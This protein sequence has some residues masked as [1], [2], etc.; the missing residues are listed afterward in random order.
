MI[1]AMRD[2]G[3]Q[4]L[5]LGNVLEIFARGQLPAR[6]D[7]L[8]EKVF[9]P[10]NARRSLAISGANG[11]VGAG[12]A[13][14]LGA[15]LQPFGVRVVGLD[16][17]GAPDGIGQQYQGLVAAFGRAGADEIM[18]NIVRLTYDG[19]HLPAELKELNPAFLLE[20][21][22]EILEIKKAHY[23]LFRDS[24][25]DIAISSVT[26][27]FPS[28][29]LGVG[30]AHPAFPHQINK[31]WEIVESEPSASTQLLW[32]LGLIPIPVGD[33]WSFVLDVLFCGLM[34]AGI[35]YHETS[36]MPFWKIDKWVRRVLG[37]NPFRAHDVIGA[38]GAN[39]LTWSCLHHL[40][41]KYGDLFTPLPTLVERKDSGSDWYPPNHFRPVVDWKLDGE[42]EEELQNLL[43]GPLFQMTS[44]L[45]HEKRAPLAFMNAIG[46]LCAQFRRGMLAVARDLGA[47]AV[48]KRVTDYHALQPAVAKSVYYPDVFDQMDTPDWQQLYVNAEHDGTV[49]VITIGRES[50]NSDVDAELNRAIDWLTSE[51]I[52]R[53][54]VTG[55]FHLSTQMVGAD[56]TEF[57]PA[58][59][60]AD[61]GFRVAHT[62]SRTARRLETEFRVSVGFVNG[63]R[64]LG[65]MLELMMHC[66]YLVAVEN[67]D[68]G[69]PEVTLPVVPGMEGCHWP[70]RKAPSDQW[71]KLLELLLGGRSVKAS[72]AIGWLVDAAAP[73]EDAL[74]TVWAIV[75]DGKHNLPKREVVAEAIDG[76]PSDVRGLPPAD[77]ATTEAAR[78]AIMENIRGSLAQTLDEALSTQAKYSADF[79][80]S[81]PCRKGQIGG[82]YSKT[83]LI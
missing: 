45:L 48:R 17:P 19:K 30:I 37:P 73:M 40:G 43:L 58:L 61:E 79:M 23:K 49:G 63:K 31:I 32:A 59:A 36:N 18:A 10:P 25:P 35:G 75:T 83:M 78:R 26:S 56:T 39:F 52:E 20:A 62:W 66:N 53:A 80:L 34:Q 42:E 2:P 60:N 6:A 4:T 7:E 9:G 41:G 46:E 3:L 29:E 64:C 67:A 76:V 65:G 11:M 70:F 69:M 24:F 1:K 71:P 16:F 14:Q 50:Y 57:Y 28:S 15:R 54:I 12:K 5:G 81:D 8:V 77:N 44:L 82:E 33:H 72:E 51:G 47:D 38:K 74:G 55:D 21:I 22:P 27:G 68:L 13:M